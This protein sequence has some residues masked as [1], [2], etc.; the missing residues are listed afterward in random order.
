MW[1]AVRKLCKSWF[2]SFAMLTFAAGSVLCQLEVVLPLPLLNQALHQ[3]GGKEF[4]TIESLLVILYIVDLAENCS[5]GWTSL[6]VFNVD[7]QE[8]KT[9]TKNNHHHCHNAPHKP[10]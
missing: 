5:V 7:N 6:R 8:N 10:H 4:S 1:R 2:I 3:E 9:K